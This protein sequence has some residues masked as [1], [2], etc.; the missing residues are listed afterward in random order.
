MILTSNFS[1][2]TAFQHKQGEENGEPSPKR[3][4]SSKITTRRAVETKQDSL[5]DKREQSEE[6]YWDS[7]LNGEDYN[8]NAV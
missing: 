4:Q 1:Q 7:L 3:Q 6:A 2:Y 8:L 5:N